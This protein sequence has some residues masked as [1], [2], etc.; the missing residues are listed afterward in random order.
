M[1]GWLTTWPNCYCTLN[2]YIMTPQIARSNHRCSCRCNKH[3]KYSHPLWG[4]IQYCV[5]QNNCHL[6]KS[7]SFVSIGILVNCCNAVFSCCC[8][9]CVCLSAVTRSD[10][11]DITVNHRLISWGAMFCCC[12]MCRLLVL[13]HHQCSGSKNYINDPANTPCPDKKKRPLAFLL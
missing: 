5:W 12:Q 13:T 6:I 1:L 2:T 7:I 3:A 9:T 10:M 11:L 8:H 4:A